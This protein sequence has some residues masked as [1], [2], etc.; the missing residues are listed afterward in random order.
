MAIEWGHQLLQQG[1]VTGIVGSGDEQEIA[2]SHPR[3]VVP[4]LIDR[5]TILCIELDSNSCV[6]GVFLDNVPAIVLGCV[7]QYDE[8]KIRVSLIEQ[9]PD[10]LIK[11]PGIVV[12]G[13]YDAD[14]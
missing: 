13:D 14:A 8:L 9:T 7:I 4:A 6:S 1:C 12:V 3:S 2:L 10:T 5:A 11:V